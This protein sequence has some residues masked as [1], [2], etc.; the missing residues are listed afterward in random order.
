MTTGH[1]TRGL[2]RAAHR[3]AKAGRIAREAATDPRSRDELRAAAV[4]AWTKVTSPTSTRWDLTRFE[5]ADDLYRARCLADG[6]EYVS[7]T[8]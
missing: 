4:A 6:V 2:S 7:T 8:G 1:P 5:K 3:A